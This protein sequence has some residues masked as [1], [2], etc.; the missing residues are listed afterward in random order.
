[1]GRAPGRENRAERI[2]RCRLGGCW[3]K[4]RGSEAFVPL[5]I[6]FFPKVVKLSKYE[7]EFSFNKTTKHEM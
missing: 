7:N 5:S 4:S 1:M 6:K 3:R 2:K